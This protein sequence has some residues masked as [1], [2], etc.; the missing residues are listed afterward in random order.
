MTYD[1]AKI[2]KKWQKAWH[3]EKLFEANPNKQKKWFGTFPYPYINAFQHVGHFY[4]LM[5]VEADARYK[6][7]QGFNVLFPQGWHATGSPII[8]AAKRVKEKEPKQLKILKDM[9]IAESEIPKFEKSEYWVTFFAPEFKKDYQSVGMSVDWRR[10]FHTTSLNPHYDTFVRWQFRKLKEKGYVIKKKFPVVWDP[11]EKVPVGDHDRIEGEGITTQDFIWNKFRMRDSDLILI[12][13]TTR[14]DALYGQTN[15]WVD[16]DGRYVI[17]KVKDE[18][19]V[20]G[21]E[22]VYKIKN[23]HTEEFEVLGSIKPTEL[24]GKWAKGPLVDYDVHVLPAY[25]IDSSVGSGIVYSALEDPV[26]LYELAK[27]QGDPSYIKK[28]GLDEKEVTR[29]H[30][31]HIIDV[32]G[33]GS[34]LGKEI[35]EKFGVKSA[36]DTK[37]LEKAKGELNRMVFR[38]GIMRKNCGK[39]AGMT[40]PQAQEYLKKKLVQEGDSAMF[41]ELT[42]KVVSRSLAECVVKIVEDQWFLDYSNPKWKKD[43]YACLKQMKLYPEKVRNQFEYVIDWLHEWAC[44]REEGLGTRLPWDEKWLIESLSDSTIYMA[45]YTFS[46]LLKDIP[47]VQLNDAFFDYILL[48][49][50]KKPNIKNVEQMKKEFAYWYPLDFRNSGK[51]LVQN[52]LTFFIFNHVALFPKKHWPTGIGANGWVTVDGQK[53]SKSLG[54]MIPLREITKKF[55]ADISRLT[56]LSGGEGLDDPNWD[57]RL[58]QSLQPK[59]EQ[60]FELVTEEYGARSNTKTSFDMLTES[61][62]NSLIKQITTAMDETLFRSAIQKIYYDYL[63]LIREYIKQTEGKPNKRVLNSLIENFLIMLHP[64]CPHITEE[65]WMKIG[66]NGFLSKGKWPRVNNKKINTEIEHAHGYIDD[67]RSDIYHVLKLAKIDTPKKIVLITSPKWKKDLFKALKKE[68]VKDLQNGQALLKIMKKPTFA[69][70]KKETGVLIKQ[71]RNNLDKILELHPINEEKA[72]KEYKN[73]IE[74]EFSC[75]LVVEN[76]EKLK[77][78]ANGKEKNALPLKP[79]IVIE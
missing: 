14:P 10:E 7:L 72:L 35:G 45:Y 31:I 28:F 70:H 46:H 69:K 68:D 32:P 13:G 39:C 25:F 55:G 5:R 43:A 38:K 6:R 76:A 21:E 53:M 77:V 59:F 75:I 33:W 71:V 52:H 62:S 49:K 30:P 11:K 65:A 50:G 40:V 22:T 61:R 73:S 15:L 58:A 12:A 79:A 54:N 9:G 64:F 1:F 34:N 48:G 19:W 63:K 8:S 51:D 3:T 20:V 66:K 27:I 18:K 74:K 29:L 4:T 42:G 56:M 60:W 26:D 37:L 2:E 67:V 41:Y 44:T 17:V 24:I 47:A 36:K 16:P 57:S 23:Q 78:I